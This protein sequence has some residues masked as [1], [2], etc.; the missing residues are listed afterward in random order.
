MA[1]FWYLH[2]VIWK[3]AKAFVVSLM[4]CQVLQNFLLFC[5]QTRDFFN[6][7]LLHCCFD[8]HIH[9]CFKVDT[10]DSLDKYAR[11]R[12]ARIV[13]SQQ[14]ACVC[15]CSYIDNFD[16]R[17]YICRR[18]TGF[19]TTQS[20]TALCVVTLL[21]LVV[22]NQILFFFAQLMMA[23]ILNDVFP[24]RRR[25]GSKRKVVDVDNFCPQLLFKSS[26]RRKSVRGPARAIDKATADV[27]ESARVSN[28][29][30]AKNVL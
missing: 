5:Y 7:F 4:A 30:F 25:L 13:P 27:M 22:G 1:A 16:T 14:V 12:G 28:F 11:C 15:Q 2:Q 3:I 6:V 23:T 29:L 20:A 26:A 18:F 19:A 9:F 21:L 17:F 8:M 10:N 24:T